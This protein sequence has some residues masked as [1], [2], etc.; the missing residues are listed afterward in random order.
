MIMTDQDHDGSHIKGL[1]FNIFQSMWHELY[2][3]SG[4]LTSMLTPII[5]ATNSKK[6]VIEFYNMSDYEKWS[7]TANAKNGG[8]KIKYYKGLGTSD[9]KEAKEYFKNMKKVTYMSV[10]DLLQGN[11]DVMELKLLLQILPMKKIV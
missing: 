1:I 7:E 6:E 9:D 5:K 2:E 8:W 11:W 4:F 10:L 3:I